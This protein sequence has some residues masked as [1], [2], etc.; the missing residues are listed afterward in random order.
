MARGRNPG[1]SL[2]ATMLCNYHY[3]LICVFYFFDV[4]KPA[5]FQTLQNMELD[6]YKR[7]SLPAKLLKST[8]E[9]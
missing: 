2:H 9:L 5:R 6:E 3:L 7:N 1:L 8:R 4:Q